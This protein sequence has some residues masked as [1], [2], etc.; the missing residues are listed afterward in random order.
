MG[1]AVT[2]IV[3]ADGECGEGGLAGGTVLMAVLWQ[4]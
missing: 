3:D 1:L 4:L 2:G